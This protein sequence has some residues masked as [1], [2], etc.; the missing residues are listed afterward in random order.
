MRGWNGCPDPLGAV[1]ILTPAPAPEVPNVELVDADVAPCQGR[2]RRAAPALGGEVLRAHV[3]QDEGA[4]PVGGGAAAVGVRRLQRARRGGRDEGIEAPKRTSDGG[5]RADASTKRALSPYGFCNRRA[6][7]QP[8]EPQPPRPPRPPR[9]CSSRGRR[10]TGGTCNSWGPGDYGGAAAGVCAG[11][12]NQTM[13]AGP[14]AWCAQPELLPLSPSTNQPRL[15]M[16]LPRT[17][18]S[19]AHPP[20]PTP[21]HP[22]SPHP[23]PPHPSSPL[24]SCPI[25][26]DAPAATRRARRAPWRAPQARCR[27]APRANAAAPP[28]ARWGPTRRWRGGRSRG[29]C[30]RRGGRLRAGVG[31]WGGQ[32]QRGSQSK[33]GRA[34]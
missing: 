25:R 8:P 29:R 17:Q 32:R 2:Q 24:T 4:L 18:L 26:A 7:H 28:R 33:R 19:P 3:C 6:G 13:P 31:G 1:S 21:P 23:T 34:A 14:A 15:T 12:Y 22:T 10:P 16:F 9:F 30:G 11:T 20:H 27:R 5:G